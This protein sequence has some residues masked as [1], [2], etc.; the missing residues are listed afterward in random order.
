MAPD[1]RSDLLDRV[2]RLYD[3]TAAADGVVLP[4]VTHAFRARKL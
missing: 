4:Y 1:E 2:G 3:E